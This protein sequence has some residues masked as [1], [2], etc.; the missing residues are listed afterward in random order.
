MTS[1]AE[2]SLIRDG[3]KLVGPHIAGIRYIT[4]V[5]VAG[6]GCEEGG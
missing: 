2:R 6:P 3:Q 5:R 4:R 1:T